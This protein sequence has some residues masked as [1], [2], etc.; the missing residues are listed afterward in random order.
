MIVSRTTST[1]ERAF[2]TSS[3]LL[4]WMM[5]MMSFTGR[6]QWSEVGGSEQDILSQS[7]TDPNPHS[8]LCLPTSSLETPRLGQ[9]KGGESTQAIG[10][11]FWLEGRLTS[12]PPRG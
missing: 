8:D 5:A 6:G 2:L 9:I 11:S 3:S 4:G 1:S 10:A 12:Q 7:R